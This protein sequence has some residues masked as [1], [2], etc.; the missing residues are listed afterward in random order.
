VKCLWG[1]TFKAI[2]RKKLSV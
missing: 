1:K 2:L